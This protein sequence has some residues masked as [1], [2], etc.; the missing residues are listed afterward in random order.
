[1]ADQ[2]TPQERLEEQKR[3]ILGSGNL[4]VL[5]QV[6][7]N[8]QNARNNA[9]RWLTPESTYNQWQQDENEVDA[10]IAAINAGVAGAQA[11]GQELLTKLGGINYGGN[12]NLSDTTNVGNAAD[13]RMLDDLAQN[14]EAYKQGLSN[15][16]ANTNWTNYGGVSFADEANKIGSISDRLANRY[17]QDQ[18]WQGSLAKARADALSGRKAALSTPIPLQ[19]TVGQPAQQPQASPAAVP[20]GAQ[21]GWQPVNSMAAKKPKA[22]VDLFGKP[23]GEKLF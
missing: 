15:K 14:K 11:P 6:K 16:I 18:T 9:V 4:S 22:Q 12:T 7:A 2:R 1:M 23:I 21:A 19:N 8:I 5:Q 3:N 10:K 13:R 17:E 20:G